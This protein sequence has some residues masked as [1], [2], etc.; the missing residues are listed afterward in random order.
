MRSF[1]T[2]IAME[3]AERYL[4]ESFGLTSYEARA[5]LALLRSALK[6]KDVSS[7]AGI[8]MPRVYDTLRGLEE[9]GFVRK[10]ADLYASVEPGLALQARLL[11]RRRELE[12][13]YASMAEAKDALARIL[14]RAPGS[15]APGAR[16][17][18]VLK[19]IDSIVAAFLDAVGRSDDVI[20][21]V[22]KALRVKGAFR[23]YLESFPT[24]GKR[25]RLLLPASSRLAD[26]DKK[27]LSGIGIEVKSYSNPMLDMMVADETDVIVGVPDRSSDEPFSAIGLWIQNH[28]F[29]KSLR[30][31][32]E[33]VWRQK[34]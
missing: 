8:P 11:G 30:A 34:G 32:L 6:P 16:E 12:E 29:A 3:R 31:A 5:Y 20:I 1:G 13:S 22:R 19:G 28:A 7:A 4:K 26:P 33:E 21:A 14:A 9:K 17:P 10:E 24:T 27:F 23:A 2:G 15:R 18:V 25:I